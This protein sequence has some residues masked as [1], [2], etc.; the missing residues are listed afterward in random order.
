MPGIFF[1]WTIYLKYFF[2]KEHLVTILKNRRGSRMQMH[3]LNNAIDPKGLMWGAPHQS[4]AAAFPRCSEGIQ[5]EFVLVIYTLT[6][7][8][9]LHSPPPHA[10]N[11]ATAPVNISA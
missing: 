2:V 6:L 1:W 4:A 8:S 9:C 5:Q 11:N 3:M 10:F 7:F